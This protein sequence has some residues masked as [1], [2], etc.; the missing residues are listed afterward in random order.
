MRWA[1]DLS[2]RRDGEASRRAPARGLQLGST[3]ANAVLVG[4]R[5]PA[6]RTTLAGPSDSTGGFQL[7]EKV[8]NL[9]AVPAGLLGERSGGE[10]TVVG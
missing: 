2:T 4:D 3:L 1:F 8:E 6:C 5:V 10:S 7:A 9:I